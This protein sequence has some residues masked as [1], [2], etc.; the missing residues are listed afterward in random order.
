MLPTKVKQVD[1]SE[2]ETIVHNLCNDKLKDCELDCIF[3]TSVSGTFVASL[4]S[5]KLNIPMKYSSKDDNYLVNN[6]EN[7]LLVDL[8]CYDNQLNILKDNLTNLFPNKIFYT[9]GVLA[10]NTNSD[11]DFFGLKQD[12]YYL[13]PWNS[14]SYTPNSHLNR[15]LEDSKEKFEPNQIFLLNLL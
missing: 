14:G 6:Y 15:L 13:T 12:V 7:I 8:I 5:K 3:T 9:C 10:D 4:I 11:F 2:I 1:Y